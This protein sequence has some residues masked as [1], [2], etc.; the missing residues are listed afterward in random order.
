VLAIAT[1]AIYYPVCKL[2]FTKY[3]DQV[4]VYENAN[5]ASGL[6][7]ETVRWAFTNYDAANWHPVTWLSHALDCQ[8][9]LLNP[10]PHHEVNLLF[11]TLNVLLLF[12]VLQRAT[13][14]LGRSA[15]VAALFAVHPTGVESVA[16]VAE[17]KNLLSL[18]FFLL[19]LGAY[20]WYASAA[21]P[22]RYLVVAFLYALGLMSKPQVIT[23]PFVLLLWDYWPLRRMLAGLEGPSF[24]GETA[25]AIPGRPVS[26]LFLEKLPLLALSAVS[27]ILTL[28]AQFKGAV[29]PWFPRS[30]RLANAIVSY[31]QYVGKALWPSNLAVFYPHSESSLTRSQVLLPFAAMV[32]ITV[33]VGVLWQR[34]YLTVGWLWF[35]G[36][37]VPMI[38]LV[39]V[40]AQG[41]ADR[42][43]YLPFIGLFI[44]LCWGVPDLSSNWH[45]SHSLEAQHPARNHR[46]SVVWQAAVCIAVLLALAVVTHRQ[47]GFWND[48]LTLWTHALQ[49]TR[50][51]C[52]AEDNLAK[53][54][55]RRGQAEEAMVHFYNAVQIQPN[56]PVSNLNV[57]AYEA[58][59]GNPAQA[60]GRFLKVVAPS[61]VSREIKAE[62]FNDMGHAYAEM[63]DYD[64][65]GQSYEA[66][67]RTNPGYFGAWIGLGVMAQKV[68]KLDLAVKAYSRAMEIQP[69]D[70]GYLLLA[71]VLEQSGRME[72]GRAAN[73]RAKSLSL[74]LDE[75]R[76]AAKQKLGR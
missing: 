62:A 8:L 56:D 23:L 63:G 69:E 14:Y 9:F 64:H 70:W 44:M 21:R 37:L 38:G 2:P 28:E 17:R 65:A 50:R 55:E 30:S 66:A 43:A 52:T 26:W 49:V 11:H 41:M 33:L 59:H 27:A 68:G 54:L 25:S 3:D 45:T 18:M 35:A 58:Q 48:D 15:M 22:D 39:Q 29:H 5:V 1:I 73:E 10:A 20:R 24:T 7:W 16:W 76:H 13:G 67:V 51:N 74:D 42:Y 19:A 47:I 60:I 46:I 36:T 72:E 40:G 12:W 53:E 4:Y 57:G 32:L 31:P 75:A 34:R 71:G 6:H 61:D